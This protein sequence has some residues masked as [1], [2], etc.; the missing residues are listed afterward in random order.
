MSVIDDVILIAQESKVFI[1]AFNN[2]F[3]DIDIIETNNL[4]L[5]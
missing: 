5:V 4:N 2:L 3:K 1:L